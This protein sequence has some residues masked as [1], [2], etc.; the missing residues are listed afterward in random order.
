MRVPFHQTNQG[1]LFFLG[2]DELDRGGNGLVVDGFHAL[3][4]ECS[5]VFDLLTGDSAVFVVDG[6]GLDHPARAEDLLEGTTVRHDQV[7]GIVLVL[8]LFLG[9]Q[10]IEVA[11][12]LVEAVVRRQM[13][14]EV[15]EVVLAELPG[16]VALFLEKRSDGSVL[17]L[18]ALRGPR[19]ADLGKPRAEGRL[20]GDEGGSA[21]RAGLLGVVVGE[22]DALIGDP[23]DV[24]RLVAHQPHRVG[25]DVGNAR[26][27]RPR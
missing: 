4:G 23:V 2:P 25:R 10:M 19:H 27:R 7:S 18:H 16:R 15:A 24:G 17:F 6:G 14:V 11:E 3:L 22:D 5:G 21:G 26:H 13:L 20:P 12:E 8:R 9:V 1:V